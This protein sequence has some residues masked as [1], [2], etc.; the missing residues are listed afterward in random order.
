MFSRSERTG[1]NISSNARRSPS[2]NQRSAPPKL[3][4]GVLLERQNCLTGERKGATEEHPVHLVEIRFCRLEEWL[5]YAGAYV[6][7]CDADL[8]FG[9]TGPGV[10]LDLLKVLGYV[11]RS[12]R[13][14][15]EGLS[16]K[17][18]KGK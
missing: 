18:T 5:S 14:N 3:V 6:P 8:G 17:H 1:S 11:L 9:V 4:Y 12:V 10:L 2:E 13:G 7:E 15:R 16:L